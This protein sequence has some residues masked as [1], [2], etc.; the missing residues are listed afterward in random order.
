MWVK[1]LLCHIGALSSTS[2]S[3]LLLM[4]RFQEATGMAWV[5]GSVPPPRKSCTES[6]ALRLGFGERASKYK[7]CLCLSPCPSEIDSLCV[8]LTIGCVHAYIKRK[9]VSLMGG[10]VCEVPGDSTRSRLRSNKSQR[11]SSWMF[12][13]D[14]L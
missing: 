6:P 12:C 9:G 10:Q 1:P 4:W 2:G 13:C 14:K 3:S 5:T 7:I 11:E 8:P